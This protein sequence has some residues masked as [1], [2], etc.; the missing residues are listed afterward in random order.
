MAGVDPVRDTAP[1]SQSAGISSRVAALSKV[2]NSSD[3]LDISDR[4]KAIVRGLV[5]TKR[6]ARGVAPD[7]GTLRLQCL[8]GGYYWISLDG[9]RVLRGKELFDADEL[10]QKFLDAMARAGTPRS[11]IK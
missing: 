7:Q 4:A 3:E 8:S 1:M 5:R 6:A 10:Q 9:H 2:T 11:A